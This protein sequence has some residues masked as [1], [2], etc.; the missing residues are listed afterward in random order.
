M[1]PISH[2]FLVC[3]LAQDAPD[4][5]FGQFHFL[6]PMIAIGFLFYFMMLKPEQKK[7]KAHDDLVKNLKKNARVVTVGGIYGT[8]VNA[9]KGESDVMLR[10]DDSSNTR[11]RV[12]RTAI[13]Q[14]ITSDD[15][16]E[17]TDDK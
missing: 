5:P 10:V 2:H 8:V 15:S 3:L 4:G 9:Q 17:S 6:V 7:R 13:S 12:L 16:S 11:L 1:L 14:V